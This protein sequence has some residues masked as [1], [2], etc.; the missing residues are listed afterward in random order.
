M[1]I[2]NP[3]IQSYDFLRGMYDDGY[4]PNFLVDKSPRDW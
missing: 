2:Q 1:N 4:F 3:Q